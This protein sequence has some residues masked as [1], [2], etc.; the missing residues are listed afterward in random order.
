MY[1]SASGL[2]EE[3]NPGLLLMRRHAS[4]RVGASS[5]G[6]FDWS[7]RAL[8]SKGVCDLFMASRSLGMRWAQVFGTIVILDELPR[9]RAQR[10]EEA[11]LA[12]YAP[13]RLLRTRI[14]DIQQPVTQPDE[15]P[16][17]VPPPGCA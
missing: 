3:I 2:S 11:G 10:S 1:S 15:K 4:S 6:A 13:P 9:L 5:T 17:R 16:Q 7:R 14:V 12:P 8:V